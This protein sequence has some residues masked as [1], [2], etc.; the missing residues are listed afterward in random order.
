MRVYVLRSLPLAPGGLLLQLLIY[1][2]S[3]DQPPSNWHQFRRERHN[4]HVWVVSHCKYF[5]SCQLPSLPVLTFRKKGVGSEKIQTLQV[6]VHQAAVEDYLSGSEHSFTKQKV[7][8]CGDWKESLSGQDIFLLFTDGLIVPG[9]RA[10]RY[11]RWKPDLRSVFTQ[12]GE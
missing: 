9:V 6:Y 12:L 7:F 5:L 1:V 2:H 4:H 8:L 11:L 3:G 10:R